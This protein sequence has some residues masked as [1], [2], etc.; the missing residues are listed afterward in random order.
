M[1]LEQKVRDALQARA[2]Y[3]HTKARYRAAILEVLKSATLFQRFMEHLQVQTS[4]DPEHWD[5]KEAVNAEI[6]KVMELVQEP[7]GKGG[8]SAEWT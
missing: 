6:P 5:A 7:G 1:S 4:D 3:P 8:G 2:D